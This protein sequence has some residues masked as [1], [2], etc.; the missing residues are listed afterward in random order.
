[1]RVS[2]NGGVDW[3]GIRDAMASIVTPENVKETV[4]K[5]QEYCI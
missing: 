3:R 2:E 5:V 4:E 1:V